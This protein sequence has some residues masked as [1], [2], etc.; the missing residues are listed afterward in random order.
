VGL[1]DASSNSGRR[2]YITRP[3]NNGAGVRLLAALADHSHIGTTQRC[4]DVNADQLASA[5]E[6]L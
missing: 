1:K 5:V 4:I 3:S 6:L 2:T